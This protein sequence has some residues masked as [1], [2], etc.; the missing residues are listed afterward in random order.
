MNSEDLNPP[1]PVGAPTPK[2]T[3]PSARRVVRRDPANSKVLLPVMELAEGTN[4]GE[5]Y[6]SSLLRTQLWLGLRFAAALFVLLGVLAGTLVFVPAVRRALV[7]GIPIG[8]ILLGVLTYP[9]FV[10]FGWIY[11]RRAEQ[12]EAA[13]I[14]LSLN[15]TTG[16]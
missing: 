6:L 8:W 3:L 2:M 13:F 7:F 9:S 15:R 14:D 1:E 16:S 10:L 11:N 12:N 5:A 4:V